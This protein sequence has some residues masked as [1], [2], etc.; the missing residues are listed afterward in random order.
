MGQTAIK[1]SKDLDKKNVG[2]ENDKNLSG[3]PLTSPRKTQFEKKQ[4]MGLFH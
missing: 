4:K 1:Y 3:L 2:L